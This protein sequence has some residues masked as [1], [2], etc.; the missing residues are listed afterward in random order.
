MELVLAL[1]SARG[2]RPTSH[3]CSLT[4]R[5]TGP[6][7]GTRGR[8]F[9]D[10]HIGAH[11]GPAPFLPGAGHFVCDRRKQIATCATVA[12][13]K[14]LIPVAIGL[15]PPASQGVRRP[16]AVGV[17]PA[18]ASRDAIRLSELRHFGSFRGAVGGRPLS[19]RERNRSRGRGGEGRRLRATRSVCLYFPT[20]SANPS[21]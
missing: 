13:T 6:M 15:R 12:L 4:L 2:A 16:A 18:S 17:T 20:L 14:E 7:L 10:H 8:C 1:R 11:R 21:D 19:A 9:S 3:F 5:H